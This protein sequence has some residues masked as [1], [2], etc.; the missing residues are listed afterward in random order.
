MREDSVN[1]VLVF[2]TGDDPDR[3]TAAA[4]DLDVYGVMGKY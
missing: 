1:D 2:D 3:F 4:T